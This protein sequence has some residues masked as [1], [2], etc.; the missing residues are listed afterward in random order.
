MSHSNL[1]D[2]DKYKER[3]CNKLD[4]NFSVC[5]YDNMKPEEINSNIVCNIHEALDSKVPMLQNDDKPGARMVQ[6]VSARP[7]CKRS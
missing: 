5:C 2:N 6:S 7:W 1:R 3:F 4:D